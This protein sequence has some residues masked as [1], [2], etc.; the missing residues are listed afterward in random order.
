MI[1]ADACHGIRELTVTEDDVTEED[2]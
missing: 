1:V 2:I